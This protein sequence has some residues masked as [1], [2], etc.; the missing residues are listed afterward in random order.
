[1]AMRKTLLSQL[2]VRPALGNLE[3]ARGGCVYVLQTRDVLAAVGLVISLDTFGRS[4]IL[5][6]F[7]NQMWS[8]KQT[9]GRLSFG[10]TLSIWGSRESDSG[11]VG[12]EN[13]LR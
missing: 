7:W 11:F 8:S 6:S 2:R 10:A 9:F 3:Y 1:M 4:L 12:V 13:A 5:Y